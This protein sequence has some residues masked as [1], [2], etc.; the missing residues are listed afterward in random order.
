MIL[1][2]LRGVVGALGTDA[3]W[4]EDF[5]LGP[6][7]FRRSFLVAALVV[8]MSLVVA[9][10]V[11]T[12]RA[13]AVERWVA[14]GRAPADAVA[15]TV[16]ALPLALVVGAFVIAFPFVATVTATLFGKA[17]RLRGWVVVRHW[18]LLFL[19]MIAAL[20]FAL[21]LAGA[22]PF[23]LA[24]SGLFIL[25]FALLAADIR[26]AQRV[27][28]FSLGAAVLVGSIVASLGMSLILLGLLAYIGPA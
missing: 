10:G 5:D 4:Y 11:E 24:N 12:E 14:Q 17:E 27:G 2:R 20:L 8:P 25:T 23:R 13:L 21:Y 19:S 9:R 28:G 16:P 3:G 26:L 22:L 7:G 1:T 18:T 6:A 15:A